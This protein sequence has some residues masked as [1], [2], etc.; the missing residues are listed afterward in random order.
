MY[1][2]GLGFK[3]AL[4]SPRIVGWVW[5]KKKGEIS[6]IVE[7][8]PHYDDDYLGKPA[9]GGDKPVR[10]LYP[11]GSLEAGLFFVRASPQQFLGNE[12]EYEPLTWAGHIYSPSRLESTAFACSL[13][14]TTYFGM[15]RYALAPASQGAAQIANT[16]S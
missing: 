11:P 14:A 16:T 2:S 8:I 13:F 6:I 12:V 3:K 10:F 4:L 9:G 5:E 15:A 1:T 7:G